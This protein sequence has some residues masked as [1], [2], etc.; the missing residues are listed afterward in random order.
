MSRMNCFC[1]SSVSPSTSGLS[2]PL[3]RRTLSLG[4]SPVPENRASWV[5]VESAIGVDP[6]GVLRSSIFSGLSFLSF[7]NFLFFAFLSFF[8]FFL[9]L[10]LFFLL[11]SDELLELAFSSFPLS[12]KGVSFTSRALSKAS[13]SPGGG[14]RTASR[15]TTQSS[16]ALRSWIILHL[17]AWMTRSPVSSSTQPLTHRWTLN[18]LDGWAVATFSMSS[19][20]VPVRWSL[21]YLSL[22]TASMDPYSSQLPCTPSWSSSPLPKRGAG[23]CGARP[24][25]PP[26]AT[27]P[28]HPSGFWPPFSKLASSFQEHPMPSLALVLLPPSPLGEP[29]LLAWPLPLRVFLVMP[30]APSPLPLGVLTSPLLSSFSLS[31]SFCLLPYATL[32][33]ALD[34]LNLQQ[35]VDVQTSYSGVHLV[36]LLSPYL[37]LS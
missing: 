15:L 17:V 33:G 24:A 18:S 11:L 27:R 9:D 20:V 5:F 21:M 16:S 3:F 25:S 1:P 7:S 13:S 14:T 2:L 35:A 37:L 28:H 31:L 36:C 34:G 12:S 8:F 30:W 4:S 19:L 22:P 32:T 6:S 26:P 29:W 23:P 10:F